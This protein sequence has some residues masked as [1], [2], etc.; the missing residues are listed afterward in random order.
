LGRGVF[1]FTK[2]AIRNIAGMSLLIAGV[3]GCL[4]PIIPGIPL[5]LAGVA[6]LGADHPVVK[7]GGAWVKAGREWMEKR[8]WLKPPASTPAG[9]AEPPTPTSGG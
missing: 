7:R 8:G 2:A 4:L 9:T 5:L 6:T 3:L 1:V